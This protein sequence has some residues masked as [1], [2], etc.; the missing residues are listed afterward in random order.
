MYQ[1]DSG[2]VREIATL[3]MLKFMGLFVQTQAVR[4]TVSIVDRYPYD[5]HQLSLP[6]PLQLCQG[7]SLTSPFG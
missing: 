6:W 1:E 3:S 7:P 5:V 4:F 2:F